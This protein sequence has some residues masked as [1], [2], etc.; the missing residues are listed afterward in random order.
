MHR[1]HNQVSTPASINDNDSKRKK[2]RKRIATET[3]TRLDCINKY[4]RR[5]VRKSHY[6]NIS[7]AIT[8]TQLLH[9]NDNNHGRH[10]IDSRSTKI[11]DSSSLVSKHSTSTSSSSSST[12]RGKK[13]RS[14]LH[15]NKEN[16]W[17]V[18]KIY[19]S[20][21]NDDNE[22]DNNRKK[23]LKKK[24]EGVSSLPKVIDVA[25]STD[26]ESI[27]ND[28]NDS[29]SNSVS[30][31]FISQRSMRPPLPPNNA[32]PKDSDDSKKSAIPLWLAALREKQKSKKRE[33]RIQ[34]GDDD[35]KSVNTVDLE[36]SAVDA[37]GKKS[38]LSIFGPLVHRAI[39]K[40]RKTEIE[41][42]DGNPSPWAVKLKHVNRES[43][44]DFTPRELLPLSPHELKS[45]P[46]RQDT[47][48]TNVRSKAV[49]PLSS[50]SNQ[51]SKDSNKIENSSSTL[52]CSISPGDVIDLKN[53]PKPEFKPHE[54]P[55]IVPITNN[56]D[57]RC[58]FVVLGKETLLIAS[59]CVDGNTDGDICEE[60]NVL[61]YTAR[62]HIVTIA[63]N[64][65]ADGV[66]I[67]IED[68]TSFPLNFENSTK[69]M[70]FVQTY[71][72]QSLTYDESH[73]LFTTP[74]SSKSEESKI[75][76]ISEAR[77]MPAN[78][79]S[80]I[81]PSNQIDFQTEEKKSDSSKSS[82]ANM[83]EGHLKK[84]APT[85]NDTSK[86]SIANMLEG[87]L[88]KTMP[89]AN[90]SS[91]SNTANILEGH[92]KEKIT[93]KNDS[94][95]I[96]IANMLE[97]HFKKQIL[98][99]TEP[100]IHQNTQL[101]DEEEVIASKYRNML[102]LGMPKE[103][104]S[105]AMKRDQVPEKVI[106]AIT[107]CTEI[108]SSTDSNL[109]SKEEERIICKFRKMLKINVSRE[110]VRN[111]MTV[112]NVDNKIIEAV[113]G[114]VEQPPQ[115]QDIKQ[116]K[117]LS[118]EDESIAEK[119]KKMLKVGLPREAVQHKMRKENVSNSIFVALFGP[120][121]VPQCEKRKAPLLTEEEK[122]EVEKYQKM[123]KVGLPSELVEHDMKKMNV[124]DK[125]MSV[126]L[127]KEVSGHEKS[128]TPLLTEEEKKEVE[129]YQKMLKVG[130]PS[131]L[132][133]H[134]MKK[135]SVSDKVMS[136]VLNKGVGT[137][138]SRPNETLTRKSGLVPIHWDTL[139]N[140][141]AEKSIWSSISK[142]PKMEFD[143][144]SLSEHFAKA[145]KKIIKRVDDDKKGKNMACILD[146]ARAQNLS[147]TLNTFKQFSLDYLIDIIA[148]LDPNNHVK[149]DDVFKLSELLPKDSESAAIR[150][151]KGEDDRLIPTEIF[152]RKLQSVPRV[153]SKIGAIKTMETFQPNIEEIISQFGILS[154]TCNNVMKSEKL[155]LVLESVL[156]I[157]N[158]MNE[159]TRS[160]DAAGIKIDSLLKLAQTKSKDKKM[161]VLDYI[162][163]VFIEKRKERD[164]LDL[165]SDFPES[166]TA[167]RINITDTYTNFRSLESSLKDC[168]TELSKMK[169]D[170]LSERKQFSSGCLRLEAF[171]KGSEAALSQ[172]QS[173]HKQA[174]KACKV[175]FY[176][177]RT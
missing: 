4:L 62:T 44:S 42:E 78:P 174:S 100:K 128:E 130:L 144:E 170:L 30:A 123:L 81:T 56:N 18:K 80:F 158:I 39:P 129:K 172:V 32:N 73:Q 136:V 167:S 46:V 12:S 31:S 51:L 148:D 72:N 106:I 57:N 119:Y 68:G 34:D 173:K 71:Y 21:G 97:G 61:W 16:G 50:L 45:A 15:Q 87:H 38:V 7:Q 52:N 3:L 121:S 86:N 48:I 47:S 27:Y 54:K 14:T 111:K 125:V 90:D 104:V 133:E 127:N 10:S 126:V 76:E 138:V 145:P 150:K 95:K 23:K 101:T 139:T 77:G 49:N 146:Q 109:W 65:K 9:E 91:R 108:K 175:S 169:N 103:A 84:Q 120:T 134:D 79:M 110:A 67:S 69:C 107:E 142:K 82:I 33:E 152:F 141:Q 22:R 28:D 177:M 24:E 98:S 115:Q 96:G 176:K 168:K 74:T 112:E 58:Q 135:M 165:S 122:K 117:S 159:G 70:S 140:E 124:S 147:I 131:Q 132:V 162:V 93:P 105:H 166:H 116:P 40:P 1:E 88:K 118:S 59:R 157:G 171:M 160:G 137:S 19:S 94:S 154:T 153:P 156:S 35:N 53:L 75:I 11:D 13:S 26:P 161:S 85:R 29:P 2:K 113:L 55:I 8:D 41:S 143:L 89:T 25:Q 20:K 164:V 155:S 66:L 63:L 83:L 17:K 64:N 92:L 163:M 114:K 5:K 37:I 99:Q 149:G 60:S 36:K 6:T 43:M 102:N 151:Y